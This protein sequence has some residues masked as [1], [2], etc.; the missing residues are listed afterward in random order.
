MAKEFLEAGERTIVLGHFQGRGKASGRL[1][2]APYAHVWTLRDGKAVRFR[3]RADTV[4]IFQGI[5]G[6]TPSSIF[7]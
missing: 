6:D 7:A 5:Q 1:L 3:A 2:A 4:R